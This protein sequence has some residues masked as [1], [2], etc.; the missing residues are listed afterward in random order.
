MNSRQLVTVLFLP[1]S[2]CG[3]DFKIKTRGREI[4][5]PAFLGNRPEGKARQGQGQEPSVRRT[6]PCGPRGQSAASPPEGCSPAA[7]GPSLPLEAAKAFFPTTLF[8]RTRFFHS[9]EKG[10]KGV[11]CTFREQSLTS[12]WAEATHIFKVLK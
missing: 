2:V 10:T 5:V 4:L 11:Y 9:S 12:S 7:S 8:L 6:H 3:Q 1:P